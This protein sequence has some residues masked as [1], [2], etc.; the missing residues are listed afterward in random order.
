MTAQECERHF[1]AFNARHM[2][3]SQR[4]ICSLLKLWRLCRMC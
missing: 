1:N 2:I 3:T 4:N